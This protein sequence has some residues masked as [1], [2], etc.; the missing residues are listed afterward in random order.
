MLIYLQGANIKKTWI[1][2]QNDSP[3]SSLKLPAWIIL[4]NWDP[5]WYVKQSKELIMTFPSSIEVTV[6]VMG[7]LEPGPTISTI[8]HC[9][10]VGLWMAKNQVHTPFAFCVF[11]IKRWHNLSCWTWSWFLGTVWLS[12]YAV[13][14]RMMPSTGAFALI[15]VYLLQI[16]YSINIK[17]VAI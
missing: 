11:F 17:L 1:H 16:F 8:R 6:V 5:D 3:V 13:W 2:L 15:L 7:M 12:S 4:R 14:W 9:L 10:L